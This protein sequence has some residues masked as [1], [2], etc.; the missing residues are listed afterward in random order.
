MLTRAVS[1]RDS[2]ADLQPLRIRL[3]KLEAWAAVDR[4]EARSAASAVERAMGR[5]PSWV[6]AAA[7]AMASSTAPSVA[8]CEAGE[9]EATRARAHGGEGARTSGAGG[10]VDVTGSLPPLL[11]A[12]SLEDVGGGG[13]GAQRAVAAAI[14]A[15]ARAL[16]AVAARSELAALAATAAGDTAAS[17]S[18]QAANAQQEAATAASRGNAASR[19]AAAVKAIAEDAAKASKKHGSKVTQLQLELDGLALQLQQLRAGPAAAAA[20]PAAPS[21]PPGPTGEAL[22]LREAL[23][24]SEREVAALKKELAGVKES[25][26]AAAAAAA[27]AAED[28]AKAASRAGGSP[29]LTAEVATAKDAVAKLQTEVEALNKELVIVRRSALAAEGGVARLQKAAEPPAAAP[30]TSYSHDVR[31]LRG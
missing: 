20:G 29:K 19:Q 26:S 8:G 21:S 12:T 4:A 11:P 15:L 3:A 28:A 7:E 31:T 27:K 25:A 9:D 18:S 16:V 13:R 23:G 5:L 30:A 6:L 24:R 10:E 2:E 1:R 17:A 14:E 22:A